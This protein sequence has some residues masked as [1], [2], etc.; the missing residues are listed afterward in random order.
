MVA[1]VGGGQQKQI[2]YSVLRDRLYILCAE[3]LR[4]RGETSLPP[5]IRVTEQYGEPYSRL[6]NS[7]PRADDDYPCIHV[8][9]HIHGRALSR[10]GQK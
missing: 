4:V 10:D 2:T 7:I 5:E 6:D 8:Y 3:T 9:I 1:N